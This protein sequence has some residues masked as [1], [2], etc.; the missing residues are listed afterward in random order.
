MKIEY[1]PEKRKKKHDFML[2]N[3]VKINRGMTELS[4]E[5]FDSIQSNYLDKFVIDG[6]I[7]LHEEKKTTTRKTTRKTNSDNATVE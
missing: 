2:I 7:I 4:D 5:Q 1:L 6:A 3:K